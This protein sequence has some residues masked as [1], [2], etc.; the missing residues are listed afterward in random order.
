[1]SATIITSFSGSYE[2][3]PEIVSDTSR[4]GITAFQ[5]R[6]IGGFSSLQ[7][8]FP[9]DQKVTG[10]PDL[11]SGNFNVVRRNLE[12]I[13][14]DE[15]SGLYR[16][17]VS[18]EGGVP[19]KSLYIEESSY[20]T[21]Q[22]DAQG[23]VALPLAQIQINY[24][25]MWLYPS[26]T[27]TSNSATASPTDAEN[28]AKSLASTR[29]VQIVKD[30]PTSQ[31]GTVSGPFLKGNPKLNDVYV[32]GSSVEKAGGIFRVRATASKAIIIE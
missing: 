23:T 25:L 21:Q 14:G 4:D 19:N 22:F 32:T 27:I 10:V 2:F 28:L 24:T 9:I 12:H 16:L 18:L 13:A 11:P 15:S 6:I 20:A 31:R 26:V 30:R 8:A 5:F 7:Q 29:T 17:S 1:M 3:E